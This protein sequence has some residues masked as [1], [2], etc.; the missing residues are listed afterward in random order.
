M[1]IAQYL[2]LKSNFTVIQ[3]E[4]D[5]A[6]T[7]P[8]YARVSEFIEVEFPPRAPEAVITEQLATLDKMEAEVE[9]D[10][11]IK[12]NAIKSKRA[13]L[14]ALTWNRPVNESSEVMQ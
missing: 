4:G 6:S 3:E 1:K 7:Y 12:I 2:N 14:A 13:E 10:Y 11:A 5:Y 8:D 9:K